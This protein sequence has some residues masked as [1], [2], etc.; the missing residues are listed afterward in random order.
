[1]SLFIS[2]V[3]F[4]LILAILVLVHEFGH[5]IVAKKS[6]IRVDEFGF[7]FPPRAKKLFTKNGTDFTLNWIPFG[8]FVKIFG[9]NG[10]EG[11]TSKD[12]FVSKSKWTQAFVLFAGPLFNILFAWA[13]LSLMFFVGSPALYEEQYKD[14]MKN[15]HVAVVEILPDS[16]ADQAGLLVGDQILS[17]QYVGQEK[18]S[19]ETA[20]DITAIIQGEGT[21]PVSLEVSRKDEIVTL[22]AVPSFGLY[23]NQEEPALGVMI[24]T[25]GT[26]RLP[27]HQ[28]L[29][30]GLEKTWNLTE[31]TA[32]F[33]ISMIG[34]LLS[35]DTSEAR[36]V[37]GPVG[38]VPV[39]GD[40]LSVGFSFLVIIMALI[41]I[42][43]AIINLLPFPALDGGRLLFILIEAI[44]GSPINHKTASWVN[45][46]GFFILILL[47]ILITVR[48]ISNLF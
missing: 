36:S 28:A 13:I 20:E 6:G 27:I 14:S 25:I 38:I 31:S 5:F 15:I 19:V 23:E 18:I 43:L 39:V 41:S 48:D 17:L 45:A 32:A 22:E 44:K 46:S 1:M 29:W 33:L 4:I 34:G 8:G 10:E 21:D 2:I 3:V 7:G 11:N 12:S 26:L 37:T 30:K 40:A 42:N 16:P 24:D 35:G 47:M 9:E